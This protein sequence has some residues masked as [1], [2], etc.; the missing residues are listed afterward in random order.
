MAEYQGSIDLIGGLRPKNN[1]TFPLMEAKDIQVDNEGTRLDTAL[2][3]IASS[4]IL[5]LAEYQALESAGELKENV[6]YIVTLTQTE[7]DDLEADGAI[8]PSV[9]YLVS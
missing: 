7:Y 9:V 4:V 5:T 6:S 2:N 1:G 8:V 3:N